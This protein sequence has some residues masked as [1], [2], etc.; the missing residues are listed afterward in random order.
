[1]TVTVEGF[2]FRI[3]YHA[4]CKALGTK[5]NRAIDRDATFLKYYMHE[6]RK[7]IS[8]RNPGIGSRFVKFR[9]GKG[10]VMYM[11]T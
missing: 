10:E 6:Q 11:T 7:S 3:T 5:R 9:E 8:L 4:K 1:M 2:Y